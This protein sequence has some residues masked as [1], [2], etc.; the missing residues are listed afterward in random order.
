MNKLKEIR[1]DMGFTRE[2]LADATDLTARAIKH[3]E[4]GSVP[5]EKAA[6]I[7]VIKLADALGVDPEDL[8]EG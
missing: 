5:L 6:Y 8:F 2:S 1:K 3:W 4:D 7:S